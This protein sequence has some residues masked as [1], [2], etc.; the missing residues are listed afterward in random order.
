MAMASVFSRFPSF[1]IHGLVWVLLGLMLLVFSPLNM[2]VTMPDEFWVKQGILFCLWIGAF[3]LNTVV[4]VPR[5][6]FEN[7]INLFIVSAFATTL[8][9]VAVIWL[10]EISLNL[11][12]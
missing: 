9:V 5:L 11:P 7:K 12:T 2:N 8:A 10:T 6:L 3:Y 4:W 1:L